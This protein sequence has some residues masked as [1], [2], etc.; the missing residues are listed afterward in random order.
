MSTIRLHQRTTSTPEQLLAALIDFGPGRSKLEVNES[1]KQSA[2]TSS[3]VSMLSWLRTCLGRFLATAR[4]CCVSWQQA[5]GRGTDGSG[6][7]GASFLSHC[8]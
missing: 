2:Y 1:C 7:D 6:L 5:S 4:C 8:R 3:A